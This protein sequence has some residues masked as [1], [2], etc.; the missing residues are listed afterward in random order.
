MQRTYDFVPFHLV[1]SRQVRAQCFLPNFANLRYAVY[2]QERRSF[3]SAVWIEGEKFYVPTGD[4]KRPP[5]SFSFKP[6]GLNRLVENSKPNKNFN[7]GEVAHLPR[8]MVA[9][10]WQGCAM[11]DIMFGYDVSTD[12]RKAAPCG[13]SR[14][15]RAFFQAVRFE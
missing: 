11:P 2:C 8:C 5:I 3:H 4:A 7:L 6:S 13:D 14:K 9:T 15:T 12:S 10:R 1:S